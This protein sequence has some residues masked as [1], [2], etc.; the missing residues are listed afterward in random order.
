MLSA[1]APQTSS[2]FF[3]GNPF[4]VFE[5]GFTPWAPDYQEPLFPVIQEEPGIYNSGSENSTPNPNPNPKPVVWSPGSDGPDPDQ[6]NEGPNRTK[7]PVDER[8]L[9][10]MKSNRESAKRSRMRKQKHL[11]GLRK[12]VTR[13][14]I[15]NR[16]LVNRFRLVTQHFV[17]VQRDNER[18]QSESAFLRER[19]W[20]MHQV[21]LVRELQQQQQQ[22]QT[23]WSCNTI[24]SIS[25][26]NEL[27]NQLS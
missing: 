7:S 15:G 20:A 8:R 17:V 26:I 3:F 22:Q 21:L 25:N 14:K 5:G 12:E 4:P 27:Q 18:L 9:R 10:R 13:L 11:E 23:A 19:L 2:D 1:F 16:E 24:T 6:S